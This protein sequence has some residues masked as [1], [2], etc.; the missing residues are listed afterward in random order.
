MVVDHANLDTWWCPFRG[1]PSP[2]GAPMVLAVVVPWVVA[3]LRHSSKAAA[4]PFGARA[5]RLFNWT[6]FST[7]CDSGALLRLLS[8]TKSVRHT[9]HSVA[10]HLTSWHFLGT[11]SNI[12][13]HSPWR[14]IEGMLVTC[15]FQ[16]NCTGFHV[17]I[18]RLSW[19]WLETWQV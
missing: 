15:H 7:C 11:P 14:T 10:L 6:W 17:H 4:D 16:Y 13:T 9:I 18:K 1:V 19:F 8:T 2:V 12:L 3:T 5:S